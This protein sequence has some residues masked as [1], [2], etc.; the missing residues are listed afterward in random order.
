MAKVSNLS[1]PES[2]KEYLFKHTC[3]V[4]MK[5]KVA[6]AY[7][8]YAKF[9]SIPFTKPR[10]QRVDSLPFVPLEKE[11]EAIINASRH[12]RHATLL[13]LLFETGLRIGEASRLQFKDFD[14]E[15]RTV[16]VV[17]EKGSRARELKLSEKLCASLKL[18]YAQYPGKPFP[19]YKAAKKHM[20][21]TRQYLAKAQ[22]NP[23]FL[24]I[25][26][27]SL[28]H[29]RATLVYHE[30]KD[31]LYTQQILGHRSISNTMKYTHLVDW[32]DGEQYLTKVAKSLEEFTGYL[33]NGFEYVADYGDCKI[34]RK[35]R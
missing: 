19:N 34:L 9:H 3:S 12:L 2:V 20:W 25:H 24:N 17:P 32:K 5:E 31:L 18:V 10:Y 35:R 27:H 13:R 28:R 6:T 14:F 8:G 1:N 16:R 11:V 21:R 30:T 7:A 26:L 22:S 33:E 15:R 4:G 29:L 23:R